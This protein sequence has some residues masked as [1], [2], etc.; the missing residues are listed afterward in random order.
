M[1]G[2]IPRRTRRTTAGGGAGGSGQTTD[3]NANTFLGAQ[4]LPVGPA[5]RV[6]ARGW[7]SHRTIGAAIRAAVDGG[8]VTVSPGVYAEGLVLDRDVTIVGDTEGGKVE[9]V[10][11][12]GPALLVRG[13]AATVRGLTI[14]GTQPH[15]AAVAITGGTLALHDCDISGGRLAVAGWAAVEV[16]SCHVHHCGGPAVEA[17]GDARIRLSSFRIDDVEGIGVALTQSSSAELIGGTIHRVTGSGV[18]LVE[19]ASALIVDCE[20]AETGGAGAVIE[21]KSAAILRDTRLRDLARDGLLVEGSSARVTGHPATVDEATLAAETADEETSDDPRASGGVSLVDC[22]ISRVGGNGLVTADSA[23]VVARRCQVSDPGKAGAISGGASRLNLVGCEVQRS[24]STG[25]VAQGSARLAA[26][27]CTVTKAGANGVFIGDDATVRMAGSAIRDS[28]FTAVHIGGTSSVDML[29]CEVTGTPEHGVRTTDRS[30]LRFTGGA[31]RSAGMTALQIEGSSDATVRQAT[32]TDAGVGIR[33]QDTPH[34]PLIEECEVSQTAQSGLEVGPATGATVRDCTFRH[35]GAAGVF[36]DHDSR[37]TIEG[38][39]ISEA[40][41]SGLVVWTAA[42]P[43][44]RSTVVHHCR[45]NGVYLGSEVTARLEDCDVSATD[46]SAVYVGDGAA[47]T[48]RRCRV[49]DVDQDLELAAEAKPVFDQCEVAEVRVSTMP[50]DQR[51]RPGRAARGGATGR[52]IGSKGEPDAASATDDTDPEAHIAT[53]VAQLDELIGLRRAKQDVGTLVKL[54]KMVKLRLD[55]GLVA[56]PLSRHLVFAGNPGTGKT[57]VARLYGQILAA[58]DIIVSGHLVEVDR[59]MLVGEYVGHTAPKTT[60]AFRRALGGVL[61]IDEAYSL[62]PDGRGNDFGQE[63]ISTLVK[64]MEDHRD[65]VVVI[66]AGYPDQMEQFI[67]FNPGLASRF[68]R[69]LTFD[70]YTS[71]EL[72]DIVAHQATAHQYDLPDPTREALATF[73]GAGDRGEGFGNGRFARK[74]FQEMTERHAR[75]IA[76]R[77]TDTSDTIT[78]EQLSMLTAE[79]LPELDAIS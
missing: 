10:C 12:D 24:K 2:L 21:G 57:T 45:K 70:D 14:R 51:A 6:T 47:P 55:A 49:H 34:H 66:A 15:A 72:V 56:P 43:L 44:I 20:V 8:I 3:N 18:H 76:D 35:T 68:T 54:M 33:I 58:L 48:F 73:F 78:S 79:D 4:A 37:A 50:A 67:G 53:L 7:G 29:T 75:R 13:G 61:F 40:G 63:A 19:A 52:A 36:L 11:P 62:V 28:A 65:E 25:L 1:D 26:V 27:D 23:H 38:C 16:V 74:V 64:L 60:A 32:V 5:Q 69:T 42:A 17:A 31:I 77:F 22:T 39:E 30:M 71:A 59:A 41:G 9:L 46:S